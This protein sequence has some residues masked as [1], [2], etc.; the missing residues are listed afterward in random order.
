MN[1]D[2]RARGISIAAASAIF[3]GLTPIFGKQAILSGSPALAVVAIR[4]LG[5]ALIL[6]IGMAIFRRQYFYIYPLG[7]LGCLLAGILNGV[8]SLLFYLALARLEAGL[9]Q[10]LYSLYP[11]FVAILLYADG[12]RYTRIT[13][14]RLGL[15]IAALVLLSS[16]AVESVDPLGIVLMLGASFLYALHIPINQR[17]LYEAPAPTVTLYTMLAM[18]AIVL[19]VYA[20]F[21]APA[22]IPEASFLPLALLTIVTILSRVTLFAGVKSIGGLD[23]AL[24]GVLEIFVTLLLAHILLGESLSPGQ[25]LGAG[26]LILSLL[27]ARPD[28][29]P[30]SRGRGWL[31]WLLPPDPTSVLA[32]PPSES[33]PRERAQ[34]ED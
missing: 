18:T 25:W 29:Q 33:K 6:V 24:I 12:L 31:H 10:L 21:Q 14:L 13:F 23:A 32:S 17:V 16:A 2:A 9:A 3:L 26:L 19:P 22:P 20:L 28:K 4:T 30:D 1:R 7:F 5:A 11:L 34:A 8:G 15:S 27:L